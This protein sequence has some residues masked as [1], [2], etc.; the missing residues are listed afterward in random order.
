M[1]S[2]INGKTY[3]S[4]LTRHGYRDI[5]L[6]SHELRHFLNTAAEEAGVGIDVITEW[7][8]RASVGQSRVYMHKDPDRRARTL[9]DKRL[10][11]VELKPEPITKSEYDLREKGPIITTRYGIC[12]HPWT[13][14]PCQKSGD[15]LNC[16]ELLHCKG[17]KRSLAAVVTERDMVAENLTATM[18]EIEAGNRP[19]TRWVDTHTRYL[20]RLGQIIEMH[21]NPEIPDGSPVQMVGKDFT[22]AKRVID[23]KR[24]DR[25]TSAN[26]SDV[27]SQDLLNC[28][29]ELMES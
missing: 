29:K 2:S 18:K 8:G 26:L 17:H 3:E 7:S 15:C 21:Q 5:K 23:G 11:V 22:H 9:G 6:K 19:A 12:T 20:E 4:F 27:Y 13:I 1:V 24:P 10:A 16:S 25:V 14:D 28:L